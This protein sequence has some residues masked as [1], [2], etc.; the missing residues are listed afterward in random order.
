MS[1]GAH[2]HAHSYLGP[3]NSRAQRLR[4]KLGRAIPLRRLETLLNGSA[5]KPTREVIRMD[6]EKQPEEQTEKPSAEPETP[7]TA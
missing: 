3:R 7:Q 2:N 6:D 5:T 4:S 1:K